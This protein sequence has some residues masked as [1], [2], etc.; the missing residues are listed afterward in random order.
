MTDEIIY[1]SNKE[2]RLTYEV[3]NKLLDE[4]EQNDYD[5]DLIYEI[6]TS[7]V[8]TWTEKEKEE[9]LSVPLEEREGDDEDIS[10]CCNV[11]LEFVV[12]N[13]HE[14]MMKLSSKIGYPN[15]TLI[16]DCDFYTMGYCPRCLKLK[17]EC[18]GKCNTLVLGHNT[19]KEK[20][21]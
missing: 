7:Y 9:Y 17:E 10:L 18:Y 15:P 6:L 1:A 16:Y 2:P 19:Y 11:Q 8:V 12:C 13:Q 5:M 3:V 21:V 14:N 4:L 20:G